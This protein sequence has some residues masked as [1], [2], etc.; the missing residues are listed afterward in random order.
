VALVQC[1]F[2][3][4]CGACGR[5]CVWLVLRAPAHPCDSRWGLQLEVLYQVRPGVAEYLAK[6][7]CVEM[8][9][10]VRTIHLARRQAHDI[11]PEIHDSNT[12]GLVCSAS[13]SRGYLRSSIDISH[14]KQYTQ[15]TQIRTHIKAHSRC[16]IKTPSSCS[17]HTA[18]SR[19]K[20]EL[21]VVVLLVYITIDVVMS[22]SEHLLA[23]RHL[24]IPGY[25]PPP[26]H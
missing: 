7:L 13:S 21:I 18:H 14:G 22:G 10:K 8:D 23:I 15:I 9:I 2:R 17:Q 25:W 20:E 16:S 4:R 5:P 1:P 12:Q 3:C 11:R 6:A 19:V 26:G 24:S